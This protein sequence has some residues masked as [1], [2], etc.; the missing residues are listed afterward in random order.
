MK[1]RVQERRGAATP[2]SVNATDLNRI[3]IFRK[4]DHTDTTQGRE[5]NTR[6]QSHRGNY[7][8]DSPRLPP[9]IDEVRQYPT[10]ANAKRGQ[11]SKC[12]E[13]E[14]RSNRGP[15]ERACR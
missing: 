8:T 4:A 3:T 14:W 15:L 13:R 10:V 2:R 9:R 11:R 12:G 6:E 7:F 1:P 5:C